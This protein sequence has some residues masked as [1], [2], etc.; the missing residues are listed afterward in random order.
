MPMMQIKD[1]HNY[2][3]FHKCNKHV[4]RNSHMLQFMQQTNCNADVYCI[5][6]VKKIYKISGLKCKT[7][8]IVSCVRFMRHRCYLNRCE[9]KKKPVSP[10][11]ERTL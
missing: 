11:Y 4:H 8:F 3:F 9:R 2:I 10:L 5:I 1:S 7:L 6:R